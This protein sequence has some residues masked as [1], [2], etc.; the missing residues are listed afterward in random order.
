MSRAN[1][2]E[3]DVRVKTFQLQNAADEEAMNAFLAGKAVRYWEAAHS[4]NAISGDAIPS[5]GVWNIFVAYQEREAPAAQMPANRHG[6]QTPALKK[7][8]HGGQEIGM[9]PAER[10]DK[11]AE[12]RKPVETYKPHVPEH[13]MPL[14]EAIRTWR[15]TRAR[16]ERVKPFTFFNNAQLEQIVV[17][18]PSDS[19]ALKAIATNMEPPLWDKYHKELLGFL[20]AARAAVPSG[21]SNGSSHEIS[22]GTEAAEASAVSDAIG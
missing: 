18:K 9:T 4:S 8:P 6:R 1:I 2:S 14:F 15:N 19:D 11:V 3:S 12:A 10:A 22:H 17:A 20:D 21:A 13:D 5:S 7:H 16:E